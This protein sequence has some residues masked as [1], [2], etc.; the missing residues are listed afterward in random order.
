VGAIMPKI[1]NEKGLSWKRRTTKKQTGTAITI[2]IIVPIVAI[3]I[4]SQTGF[5]NFDM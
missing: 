1:E 5:I 2:A 4:V 3:L